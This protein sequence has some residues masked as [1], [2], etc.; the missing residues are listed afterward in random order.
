MRQTPNSVAATV[1][2]GAIFTA[3]I[4]LPVLAAPKQAAP[5]S[6][7]RQESAQRWFEEGAQ[8]AR[9]GANLRP[10]PFKAKNVI[11]FVGDGMGI[12][13]ISAA[14]IREGQLKGGSGEEHSL[15]FERLPYVSLSKTYSV[16]GQ[17]PDSAPTMTAMVTGIKTNQG[18]LSVTQKAKY[19]DCASARGQGVVTMLELSEALGLA[20]GI[21]STARITHATPAATYS[22]TPNRDWESDAELPA[23][24]K[25]NGCKDIA[26]QLVEFPYGDGLEVALGGG[27]GYFL[28]N[29]V[30]DPEDA[31]AAGRRKDGRNLPQEW[32]ARAA[33]PYVWN[34]AQFDAVDPRRTRHLLGLFERSHMEYEQDR[35]NDSGKEPSLADMTSKA[36]DVLEANS[37]KGYFLMV[38]GGRVDHAHHAGNA[39]RALTDTIA[40]SDAVRK[41]LEKT[42][43]RDTLIIVTAD[44]SHT[45][46]VAGYPDRGNDIL[47]KVVTNGRLALDK[48]GK[49]YTTLGYVNGPGY[50]G[51]NARPDLTAIDTT[52]QDY[53]QEATVPLSDE[54]HAAEDVAIYARGPGAHSFQGVVEQN[55]IFH[56]M[57]QSQRNTSIFLCTLLGQ[58]GN[59]R[60]R[61]AIAAPL[62]EEDLRAGMARQSAKL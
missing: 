3:L 58:C 44:H 39:S 24:A 25:A 27:R 30:S 42:S 28:P 41:A 18:V 13:T 50:R 17:T 36:I 45:F 12:S 46:T 9:D 7:A 43:E 6:P 4:A 56:V 59:G 11:L 21:V 49:P 60:G 5:K 19:G 52:H 54:T 61:S 31:G 22:H 40:L 16:D 1:L 53:L 14:R 20:T 8:T 51:P 2:G 33:S 10:S 47:G 15:S 23:E 29:T 35:P 62:M 57:A 26:R 34:K 48:N 55:T 37:R 32:A 38:E